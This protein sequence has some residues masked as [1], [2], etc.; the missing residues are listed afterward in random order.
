MA[1]Y[2][3]KKKS[4][5]QLLNNIEDRESK[6]EIDDGTILKLL[7]IADLHKSAAKEMIRASNGKLSGADSLT[8]NYYLERSS[9]S[10]EKAKE[11]MFRKR[12]MEKTRAMIDRAIED[13]NFTSAMSSQV[14][15]GKRLLEAKKPGLVQ[16]GKSL[17]NHFCDL[18]DLSTAFDMRDTVEGVM[19][20]VS[21]NET[22]RGETSVGNMGSEKDILD[23]ILSELQLPEEESG[24]ILEGITNGKGWSGSAIHFAPKPPRAHL[25]GGA[26]PRGGDKIKL[27]NKTA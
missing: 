23:D 17:E 5:R 14:Q 19:D 6:L 18:D 8:L 4:E 22:T 2:M 9:A 15:M 16:D 26:L 21:A 7:T 27:R 11:K 12:G 13:S 25:I 20:S 1:K 24:D 3:R 10:S